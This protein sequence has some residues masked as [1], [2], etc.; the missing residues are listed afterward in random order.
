MAFFQPVS[1]A[2]LV[3]T[4]PGEPVTQR[5]ETKF[6]RGPALSRCSRGWGTSSRVGRV[7]TC[8]SET[9]KAPPRCAPR[10]AGTQRRLFEKGRR[11][12]R[13]CRSLSHWPTGSR[14]RALWRVRPVIGPWRR[15]HAAAGWCVFLPAGCA[16]RGLLSRTPCG[17]SH[18]ARAG[19]SPA[20]FFLSRA[21]NLLDL[22]RHYAPASDCTPRLRSEHLM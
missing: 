4:P 5:A 7:A 11:G 6:A 8:L 12:G 10:T 22:W 9:G 17:S 3:Q 18:P 20:G 21:L 14:G 19:S 2:G 13:T 1:A 16:G 15:R